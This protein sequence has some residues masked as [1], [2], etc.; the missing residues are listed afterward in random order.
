M[1]SY[2]NSKPLPS[3]FESKIGGININT[4]K[5]IQLRKLNDMQQT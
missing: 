1:Y 2:L 5:G 4:C 3:Y